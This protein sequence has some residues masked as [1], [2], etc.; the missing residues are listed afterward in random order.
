MHDLGSGILKAV[1]EVFAG[2]ADFI[3]HFHFLRDIGKDFLGPAYA[4]LRQ[5]LR[6]YGISSHAL[7]RDTRQRLAEQATQCVGLAQNIKD[8]V[9]SDDSGLMPIAPIYS[10]C[11]W[12]LHGKHNGDGYGF[13]FDRP[14]LGFAKRLPDLHQRLPELLKLFLTENEP[15]QNQTIWKLACQLMYFGNDPGLPKTVEQLHWRS[16]VFDRLR[17]AIRIAPIV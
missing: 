12:L 6:R 15:Y 3:C 8:A 11:L 7:A 2:V 4:E 14:L 9:Y 10:L 1:S 16:I 13:P 5:H 17:T